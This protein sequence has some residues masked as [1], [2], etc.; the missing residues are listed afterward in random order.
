MGHVSPLKSRKDLSDPNISCGCLKCLNQAA[1][2]HLKQAETVPVGEFTRRVNE[3]EHEADTHRLG[4]GAVGGVVLP[5]GQRQRRLVELQRQRDG[6][7]TAA[8]L[9]RDQRPEVGGGGLTLIT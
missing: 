5:G 3:Q 8:M 7:T 2:H 9:Y 1:I 6:Q 4:G